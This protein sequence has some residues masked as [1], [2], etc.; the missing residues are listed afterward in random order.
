MAFKMQGFSGFKKDDPPNTENEIMSIMRDMI[1]DGA[2]NDEI[3]GYAGDA[4]DGKSNYNFNTRTG[5]V[6]ASGPNGRRVLTKDTE[7][8]G[9]WDSFKPRNEGDQIIK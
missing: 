1:S 3:L 4:G 9:L 7:T 2:T 6:E 5:D 8:L